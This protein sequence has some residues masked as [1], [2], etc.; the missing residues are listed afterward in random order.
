MNPFL[1][2]Q[3]KAK[4][5]FYQS[6]YDYYKRFNLGI[7]FASSLL[8]FILFVPD[9]QIYKQVSWLSLLLRSLVVIPLAVVVVA[10]RKTSNYKIMSAISLIMVHAMIWGNIWVVSYMSDQIYMNEGFLI[11]SFILLL[12]SFS[13]PPFFAMIAQ[14]GLIGD[15]LLADNLYHFS[16]LDVMLAINIQ[17]IVLLCLVDMIVT[18]FYYDHYVT[19]KKLE[20]ALF[21]DPL[22]QVFNRRQ[23]HKIMGEGHD[24]SFL[25]DNI[26]ILI[27]DVDHFKQVNDTY[28]HDEGDRILMFVADC[29]RYSLRGPDLVIR[30]GGEEFVALLF[31]CSPE[32]ASLVAERIRHSVENSVNGVC[33]ITISLGVAIYPGGDCFETIK[34]ADQALYVAKHGGRNKVVSYEELDEEVLAELAIKGQTDV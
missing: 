25:S 23:L 34:K 30:W 8:F 11:M 29:I 24:L 6:K 10:Y 19:Q 15:I 4:D 33:R 32:Q 1:E 16:N 18:R 12:A 31:D 28:G 22:T 3:G 13:A 21:H 14:L 20:F 17:V 2:L 7:L 26:A 27:M 9:W 5:D